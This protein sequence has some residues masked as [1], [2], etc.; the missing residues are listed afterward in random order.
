MSPIHLPTV[1]GLIAAVAGDP[2]EAQL[3]KLFAGQPGTFG[4]APLELVKS[5]LLVWSGLKR[6]DTT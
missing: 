2:V 5:H 1:T 4:V 6:F 3:V